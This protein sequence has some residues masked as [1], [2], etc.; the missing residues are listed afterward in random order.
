M[1]PTRKPT[2]PL[3][4]AKDNGSVWPQPVYLD[5]G[6]DKADIWVWGNPELAKLIVKLLNEHDA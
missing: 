2:K 6:T 4:V 5:D 1:N 3:W